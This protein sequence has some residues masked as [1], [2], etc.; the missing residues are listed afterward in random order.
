[1][2]EK[3]HEKLSVRRQCELFDVNR[4][5]LGP[6]AARITEEDELIMRCLDELHMEFP[7]LGSRKLRR[8]LRDYG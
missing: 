8:E 5:R 2:I 3:K 4:N 1:M 7:F 6:R